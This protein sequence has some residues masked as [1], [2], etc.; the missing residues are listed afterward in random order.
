MSQ[1]DKHDGF[2]DPRE[3][4]AERARKLYGTMCEA[5]FVRTDRMFA[6][7]LLLQWLAGVAV[8]LWLSPRTWTG[9]YNQIHIHVWGALFVGAA[10]SWPPALL[11]L[12]RPG[13]ASTRHAI[14]IAE[15]L[16]SAL[17][18]DLTGGRIETHFHI[19]G[20]LAFLAFYR[21]WRVLV[22]ATVVVALHHALLGFYAPIAVYGV[23]GIEPWRWIEHAFW[24]LFEDAFLVI[25]ILQSLKEMAAIAER[26]ARLETV[27]AEI[28]E[29]VFERTAA[30]EISQTE[31]RAQVAERERALDELRKAESKVKQNEINLRKILDSV[32]DPIL[33]TRQSDG[34][35]VEAN[36]AFQERGVSRAEAEA[37]VSPRARFNG[38]DIS[39]YRDRVKRDGSVSNMEAEIRWRD[40]TLWTALISGALIEL[41][42]TACIV[43]TVHD[44]SVRKAMEEQLVA[45]RETALSASRAKSEFLS[46][47]SHEIRTP[48]NAIL[49]MA[50]LLD[51]AD[52][53]ADQR[54]YLDVMR[55]NG[56]VLL[57]LINDILDMAKVE[58]GRMILEETDFD[59][60]SLTD[61]VIETLSFRADEKGLELLV[62]LAP[63]VE[64]ALAGD[65][66]R[67]RQILMN[68]I[69][70]SLK[71][72]E[73]GQ[74]L[75][76]V[77][78]ASE[79]ADGVLYD[80]IMLHFS[81]ADTGIGIPPDKIG[82]LFSS[83]AQVDSSTTRHYGGT[84]LGLA[85]V[86]RLVELMG[87]QVWVESEPGAG[88]TF[89][90]T[91]QFK[92]AK[93][94]PSEKPRTVTVI[95]TGVRTLVIDDNAANR[96]ILHEMLTSRGALVNEATDGPNGLA[97][98]E[99]ARAAGLPY[100]LVL[101]DCRMPGMDGFEVAEKI[102]SFGEQSLPVLMLSSDD[103]KM[104]QTRL[105]E[106]GLDAHLTKPL[107]R[108]DLFEAIA[109]AMARHSVETQ[110]R[111]GEA[112]LESTRLRVNG[113]NA[114][115]AASADTPV[116]QV[117]LADDS[118]DNRLLIRAYLKRDGFTLD[119]AEDGAIAVERFRQNKYDIVLMDV[120]MPV[121]DG[122]AATRLI[123]ELEVAEGLGR[124]PIIALTASALDEDV[125]KTLEAGADLHVSKPVRKATLLAAIDKIAPATLSDDRAPRP[126]VTAS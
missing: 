36:R 56:N 119:E 7:L 27:N 77:E 98:L 111:E 75:L 100:R 30:L 125:R 39:R 108:S 22:T 58:A 66:L 8:A 34:A 65:P 28:E 44:I 114:A 67:L 55:N 109:V 2:V 106:L 35:F 31:L 79:S 115:A 103:M 10:I 126:I 49:G 11:A 15:M 92:P 14:A 45:A 54:K 84:G 1:F 82:K 116:R 105:R 13:K 38:E 78:P 117:L 4:V 52:L 25:S 124:T 94:E 50:D 89:H 18:I 104:G 83:F 91:A 87:G 123:R 23:A 24:V 57:S 90:F 20:A 41:D 107:R 76:T 64:C 110:T 85:I 21:D 5:I 12:R 53:D 6:P 32:E 96:L 122:L 59:L 101:L 61:K 40:G 99:R 93:N 72:T 112:R 118:P 9:S 17:L 63:G 95:L 120:Q 3:A 70:N 26:Q 80:G 29:Q 68:L 86:K 46:S 51:E 69:G 16:T 48:M 74:I 71:F 97:E 37:G 73:K 19:F 47:M 62:R 33:I 121:L 43:S 88:S 42:G 60:E 102:Q 113:L 81:V